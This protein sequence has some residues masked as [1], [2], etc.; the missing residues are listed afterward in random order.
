MFIYRICRK[1]R[2]KFCIKYSTCLKLQKC[3][4]FHYDY[5]SS[6]WLTITLARTF[7]QHSA[8]GNLS[9]NLAII[10]CPKP[11]HFAWDTKSSSNRL[12]LN[13]ISCF[14]GKLS[15]LKKY[16]IFKVSWKGTTSKTNVCKLKHGKFQ[17]SWPELYLQHFFNLFWCNH[18]EGDFSIYD[19]A[20]NE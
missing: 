16:S 18:R 6:L 2:K 11:L 15:I 10:L 14:I 20:M 3:K 8:R 4:L 5:A 12:S 9:R 19:W 1:G 17:L 7:N 13:N